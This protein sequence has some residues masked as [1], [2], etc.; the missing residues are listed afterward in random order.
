VFGER[1]W[2]DIDVGAS[3]FGGGEDGYGFDAHLFLLKFFSSWFVKRIV[4]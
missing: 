3:A 4:G 1:T 2:G